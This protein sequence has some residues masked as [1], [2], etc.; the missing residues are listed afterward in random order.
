MGIYCEI[1]QII[2][3]DVQGKGQRIGTFREDQ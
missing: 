1:G 3:R 2:L